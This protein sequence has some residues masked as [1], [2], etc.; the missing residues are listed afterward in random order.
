[1]ER[2]DEPGEGLPLSGHDDGR[3]AAVLAA[4]DAWRATADTAYVEAVR[5]A[6]DTPTR[7]ARLR[8][9]AVAEQPASGKQGPDGEAARVSA[10]LDRA[11]HAVER[12]KT[13]LG[14]PL[15]RKIPEYRHEWEKSGCG[16]C[17]R[18]FVDLD[19]EGTRV[20][21]CRNCRPVHTGLDIG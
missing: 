2:R 11:T 21:R 18:G 14:I 20:A 13:A 5:I 3:K 12:A 1:M 8:A 9:P 19:G 6:W 15:E 4:F 10:Y 16:R 7:P 17:D